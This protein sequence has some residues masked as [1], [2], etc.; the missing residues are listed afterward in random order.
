M[1]FLKID[2]V[3][4]YDDADAD[5]LPVVVMDELLVDGVDNVGCGL[6]SVGVVVDDVRVVAFQAK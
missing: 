2:E 5:E 4:V 1:T 3:V 6:L